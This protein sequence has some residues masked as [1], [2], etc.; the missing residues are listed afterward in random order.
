MSYS[1]YMVLGP[2]VL[3]GV[4]FRTKNMKCMIIQAFYFGVFRFDYGSVMVHFLG[5]VIGVR[6]QKHRNHGVVGCCRA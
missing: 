5:R 6:Q 2:L 1:Q 4:S 3:Y